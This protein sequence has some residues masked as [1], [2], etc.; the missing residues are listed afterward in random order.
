MSKI[1]ITGAG[2]FLGSH[3]CDSLLA[4]RW[5][6]VGLDDWSHGRKQN[7]EL[8][9]TNDRFAF[10][11]GD[12]CNTALVQRAA[13]GAEV[14][15]HL[16]AY[17]IPRY[18]GRLRTLEVNSR[19]ME[20]VL[21]AA[22]TCGAR[23]LFTSTSDCYGKNTSV[24]F[25]ERHD[26]VLGPPA[27][28]RWAYAV[29]KNFGEHLCYGHREEFGT[30]ITI[31]RVFGSYGP[32]H[33]FSWWGGPQSVFL[34]QALRGEPLIIHGDGQQTRSFTYVADTVAGLCLLVETD[35]RMVDGEL[36][37]VGSD[38]EITIADL[39]STIWRLVRPLEQPQ[40]DYLPYQAIADRPYEDVRRRVPDAGKL[41]ALGW[42]PEWRIEAGL[43]ATLV[44]HRDELEDPT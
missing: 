20:S 43:Q 28:S 9:L 4:R 23:V 41:R 19:G 2:G 33:H 8:A 13:A 38:V 42:K 36:F 15:A 1:L 40:F 25:G 5:N 22:R 11:E 26:S 37:N 21:C 30:Q 16:A 39:A 14:I 18:G 24:P 10:V 34:T 44:W 27:V 6:V 32:R 31:A 29:S 17:K 35:P 7:L 12:V 3:L